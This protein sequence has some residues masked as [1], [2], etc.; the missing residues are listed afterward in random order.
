LFA[1][2]G[3]IAAGAGPVRG[4]CKDRSGQGNKASRQKGADLGHRGRREK[5]QGGA[6]RGKMFPFSNRIS[7][8]LSRIARHTHRDWNSVPRTASYILKRGHGA[9]ALIPKG[10]T[11]TRL[12]IALGLVAG[13]TAV[14][15]LAQ[16]APAD[17]DGNGTWSMQELQATYPNLSEEVFAAMDTS[18][19][20]QID[21]A[22]Y[23]AGL[24]ANLLM[25]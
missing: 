2:S 12:M 15:A 22:E 13:L 8:V 16:D 7:A 14:P 23:E 9:A 3:K 10:T 11:M 19:D 5:G 25:Q 20:G 17:A 1:K 18:G 4:N 21:A 24:A 6:M